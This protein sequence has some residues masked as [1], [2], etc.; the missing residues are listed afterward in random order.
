MKRILLLT[1]AL[2]L[3]LLLI[4]CTQTAIDQSSGPFII[5]SSN[6]GTFLLNVKT[7][8]VWLF[9]PAEKAFLEVPVKP[10]TVTPEDKKK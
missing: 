2:L 7:G 3:M 4:G 8:K 5:Y 1:V 10:P 6:Q 9:D